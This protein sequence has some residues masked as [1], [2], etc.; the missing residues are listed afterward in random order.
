MTAAGANSAVVAGLGSWLPPRVVTNEELAAQL[1]T[2]D[3]WIRSRTGIA[4]RR[5][6]EPG[7][8]TSDLA[9][10]AGLLAMKAAEDGMVDAVVLATTT[11]DRHCPA[12]A[13]DVASRL[14]L[15]GT[16][17]FDISAVCAGFLYGLAAS[18]GLIASGAAARILLIG[19]ETYSTILDPADRTTRAIFGDGAGAVVLRA[20]RADKPGAL[21]PCVLGS[22]GEHNDLIMIP[23]G[24]ARQRSS[25]VDAAP[26]DHYFRMRGGEVYR[27]AVD[28]MT[29]AA[30]EALRRAGWTPGDVDRFVPHQANARI[31]AAV[32]E[33]LG[34]DPE[35]QVANIADVGNTAAASVPLLLT[36]AAA[37]RRLLPGQRV[38]VTA[39]GGGLAWGATTLV[40]PRVKALPKR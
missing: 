5:W 28:R 10:E 7:M 2:S 8:T 23:A 19:A 35:R 6:V 3:G 29:A 20:G 30:Q 39:F 37:D 31:S 13:P 33:R 26:G 38:L 4:A 11:P 22:D 9:V 18:A 15:T 40:W 16:A 32:T 14:G 12:T 27:H 25:G 34:I 21:G 24:G 36:E 17:A 1:D